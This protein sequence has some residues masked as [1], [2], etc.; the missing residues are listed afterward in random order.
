MLLSNEYDFSVDQLNLLEGGFRPDETYLLITT[1][2]GKY[3][4]KYIEY[5]HSLEHLQ[6]ILKFENLLHDSYEYPCPQI[7]LS[8]KQQLVIRDDNRFL[9]IQTFVQGIEPTREILDKDDIYLHK[10]G[11]LLAQ[12]R[13]ASREYS[14]SIQIEEED[15]ELTDQ[16]WK[17]QTIH[18]VDPF[19]LSNFLECKYLINLKANFERGLIHNDFHTNNSIVTNDGN[20]FII[21]FVDACQSV[22]VAD[23]ATSLFH[24]LVDQQNGEHRAQAFLQGY[25]QTIPLREEEINVLDMFVR[26]KLA[27]SIIEDL[28]DS[29]DTDHPFI[30]SCLH[31][32]HKLNNHSTLVNNLCL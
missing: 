3:V 27:L 4:V 30:Q 26:F 23:L 14:S 28:R 15:Q 7:I 2:Q 20:I 13:M 10:M 17:K 22:F 16:W 11:H 29:N 18:N 1:D 31:L 5:S 9:F 25:Q 24:L 8:N 6:S 12:W 32:L 21:D 19:L